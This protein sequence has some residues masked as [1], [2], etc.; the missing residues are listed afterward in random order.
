MVCEVFVT[1]GVELV[2]TAP[3]S[4][5]VLGDDVI[6][7]RHCGERPEG[8]LAVLGYGFH[9]DAQRARV[10]WV[11]AGEMAHVDEVA[12]SGAGRAPLQDC[13]GFFGD[14]GFHRVSSDGDVPAEK[15]WE[16]GPPGRWPDRIAR[17]HIEVEAKQ[18]S[19]RL[20]PNK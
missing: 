2:L 1:V 19:S 12:P 17:A 16:L 13:D 4:P 6:S 10:E 3:R 11:G 7:V 15:A 9:S 14:D 5:L 20:R 8:R 18:M